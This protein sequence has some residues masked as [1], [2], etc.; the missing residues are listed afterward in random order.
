MLRSCYKTL[1][2][3]LPKMIGFVKNFKDKDRDTVKNKNNKLM[4]LYL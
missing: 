1:V 2:L 4:L 3:I